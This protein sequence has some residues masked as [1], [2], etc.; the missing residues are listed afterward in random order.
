[1][2]L[3]L[4]P[5]CFS[6]YLRHSQSGRFSYWFR[7]YLLRRFWSRDY[8]SLGG[9]S[10]RSRRKI[11]EWPFHC[12]IRRPTIFP[13]EQWFSWCT[14]PFSWSRCKA[15]NSDSSFEALTAAIFLPNIVRKLLNNSSFS[16]FLCALPSVKEAW[17]SPLIR[18]VNNNDSGG[19][20]TFALIKAHP[21]RGV[22]MP[23]GGARLVP[24]NRKIGRITLCPTDCCN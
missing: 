24:P 8:Y 23:A 15:L 19:L 22:A 13:E 21:P 10:S 11:Q 3:L 9:I 2:I 4:L 16:I 6:S 17:S 18:K 5:P 14:R 12:R 20:S 7:P 1:M